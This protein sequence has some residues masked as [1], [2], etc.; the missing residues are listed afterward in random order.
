MS[1]FVSAKRKMVDIFGGDGGEMIEEGLDGPA[2]TLGSVPK[3]NRRL[4]R[5]MIVRRMFLLMLWTLMKKC[6]L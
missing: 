4:F 3:E 6:G 5:W 1:E 2:Q